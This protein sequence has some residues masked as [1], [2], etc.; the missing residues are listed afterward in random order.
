MISEMNI[1]KDRQVT[2][3]DRSVK[4]ETTSVV[5]CIARNDVTDKLMVAKRSAVYEHSSMRIS[6]DK[7]RPYSV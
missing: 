6:V 5:E 3:D 7:L 4:P 1:S 2:H